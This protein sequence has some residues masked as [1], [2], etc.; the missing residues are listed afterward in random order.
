MTTT[1]ENDY[2]SEIDF[3]ENVPN[4]SVQ[5]GVIE[6]IS[7]IQSNN[8]LFRSKNWNNWDG[9]KVGGEPIWLNPENHPNKNDLLCHECA[10]EM[11]FLLQIY[12]P[13]DDIANAFHRCLYI[14]LCK[15]PKCVSHG[16]AKC[17]RLQLPRNNS[18]YSYDS[19]TDS[20]NE[21]TE[22]L[23]SPN[24]SC[25][26]NDGSIKTYFCQLCR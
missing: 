15:N 22:N 26:V 2:D 13:L 5:L 19:N 9:G 20:T 25:E 16:N 4:N 8:I 7:L 23:V 17:F 1:D 24:Q 10:N 6:D 12:C 21:T 14:F 3:D 11:V 18:Y